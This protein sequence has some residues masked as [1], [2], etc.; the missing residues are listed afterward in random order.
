MSEKLL[1]D[2]VAWWEWVVFTFS[3]LAA[4]GTSVSAVCGYRSYI[5]N[6]RRRKALSEGNRNCQTD[7]G[8]GFPL[9]KTISNNGLGG[10]DGHSFWSV[11]FSPI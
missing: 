5:W 6:T 4:V 10:C 1:Q 8:E 2:S 3:P 11:R 7:G 9:R